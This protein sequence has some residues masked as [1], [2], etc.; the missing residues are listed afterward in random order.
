MR[1]FVVLMLCLACFVMQGFAQKGES[2]T[3]KLKAMKLGES[4]VL[5]AEKIKAIQSELAKRIQVDQEVRKNPAKRNEMRQVDRANTA[6]L[7]K[8]IKEI[9]W[10][11]CDRFSPKSSNNAFLLVQHSGDI[12]LMLA[13][14]PLIEKDVREKKYPDAQPYCLLYDRLNLRLKGK[15]RY[16]TQISMT[17]EGIPIVQPLEDREKV[18]QFR[19]E[20]GMKIPLKMYLSIFSRQTGRAIWFS[21]D[22]Q[23]YKQACMDIRAKK[24][25]SAV[26][27]F[28]K[29]GKKMPKVPEIDYNLA[30]CY[31]LTGKKTEALVSLRK[32]VDKGFRKAKHIEKDRDLDSIRDA[33][34]YAELLKEMKTKSIK[35]SRKTIGK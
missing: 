14:L 11:D 13:V 23:L 28:E 5:E 19:N 2:Y 17:P 35:K 26:R 18:E 27:L 3:G 9:G 31:A 8:T 6:W 10:I 25:D 30:C 20:I 4:K 29:V 12:P 34:E 15:Q 33:K 32:A 22:Y 1:K 7:K 16:A 21:E 24:Y